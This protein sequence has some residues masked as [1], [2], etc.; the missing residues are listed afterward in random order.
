MTSKDKYTFENESFV[1]PQIT[2]QLRLL[3]SSWDAIDTDHSYVNFFAPNAHLSFSP[4]QD[5]HG[6]DGIREFRGKMIHPENGPV[7][8]LEH[9]LKTCWSPMGGFVDGKQ[10]VII[11]G[12]IWYKLKNGRKVGGPFSSLAV[13]ANNNK[14]VPEST[15]YQ[16]YLDTLEFN[17]AVL[18]MYKA[19][20]S[21]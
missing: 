3:Y 13:F 14:G 12:D 7:V 10:E 18:E 15:F 11:T 16:V 2:E 17:N 8:E 6:R 4:G 21:K 9:T 1:P 20:K 5:A 19:E